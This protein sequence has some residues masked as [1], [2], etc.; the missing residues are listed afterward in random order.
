MKTYTFLCKQNQESKVCRILTEN[1]GK[2]SASRYNGERG[3]GIMVTL[4]VPKNWSKRKIDQLL[5]SSKI[6]GARSR[7]NK[8]PV[9]KPGS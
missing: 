1:V 4:P 6:P 8:Y 5:F 7:K 3:V 9:I 2:P